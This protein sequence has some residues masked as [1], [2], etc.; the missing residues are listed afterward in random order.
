MEN[1]LMTQFTGTKT[2]KAC[3]MSRKSAE[4]IIGRKMR[5]DSDEIEDEEGYLVVYPDGYQ[6][7]SPKK[8][9]EDSYNVSE[10]YIDRMIIEKNEVEARYLAGRKFSFSEN[11][12]SLS[13]NQR[14][15]LRK[16]LDTMETYLY[17]LTKR[18]VVE[19]G[20]ASKSMNLPHCP[21]DETGKPAMPLRSQHD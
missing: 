6:S 14:D 20:E 21:L 10:T 2:V 1:L 8:V 18:I 16:Q 15:L 9:F 19:S 12:A 7:W 3:K 13:E 5:P 11:F 17:L 4:E